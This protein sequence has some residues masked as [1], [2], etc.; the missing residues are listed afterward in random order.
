M[1]NLTF[2]GGVNEIGGNKI[3][4]EDK[5]TR[6]FIDFGKA[7]SSESKFFTGWL[8]PRSTAR[9][10]D[11]LEFKLLP[12]LRGLYAEEYL[13]NTGIPH[14]PPQFDGIL[15]S[16]THLDHVAHISFVHPKIPIYLSN[17]SKL[18]LETMAEVYPS[19]NLG[20]HKYCLFKTNDQI[21]IG[22]I[23]IEPMPVDHSILG[24][25]GF[26]IYA[27]DATL[28]YTG[29]F[30]LHGTQ[31]YL[32]KQFI[33]KAQQAKPDVLLTEGTRMVPIE[34]RKQFTEANVRNYATELC[35]SSK[36]VFFTQYSR[37]AVRLKSMYL[38]TKHTNRKIVIT[39][40]M[41]LMLAKLRQDEELRH[42]FPFQD[43]DI[44]VYYRKKRSGTYRESDYFKWERPFMDKMVT[45][46]FVRKNQT[47]LLV[48]VD[49][50]H[51]TEL[52]DIKPKVGSYYLYSMS[53]PFSEEDI[54][55]EEVLLNWMNH[56]NI[57]FCRC[58]SS[59]HMPKE[60]L[61]ETARAINAKV[62]IP[63][64]T[65]HPAMFLQAKLP[66]RLPRKANKYT[67]SF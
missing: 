51:L 34:K 2:Y 31:P 19:M 18:L 23:T 28:V 5:D 25:Y 58:H 4:L 45:S 6:I 22:S 9:L 52:I 43:P 1:V 62:V 38:A 65:E 36:P 29:D 37:D 33:A 44:L 24:S 50:Y 35:R 54:L 41:A 7:F 17:A 21:K 11:Y 48:N 26:I 64:H 32:T 14:T 42:I 30:R 56:F 47:S 67:I 3:L 63:I 66:V 55:T 27:S 8:K 39:P 10:K 49:F 13:E 60:Q 40:K 12:K 59:G 53:E 15:I 46:D 16:H 57:A 61:V 20:V